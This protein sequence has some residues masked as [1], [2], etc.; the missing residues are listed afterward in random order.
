MEFLFVMFLLLVG[1]LLLA[2]EVAVIPG[3]GIVGISGFVSIAAAIAYAFCSISVAAGWC[4]LFISVA[5][6]CSMIVWALRSR[7]LDRLSLKSTIGAVLKD[8]KGKVAVG[9]E[10]RT[11]TRLALVGDAVI[12]DDIVEVTSLD[13]YMDAGVNIVVVKVVANTIYVKRK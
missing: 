11:Y 9:D 7:S 8:Y 12:N 5:A 3:F 1:V 10:G 6:V 4:V 13:G 2:L